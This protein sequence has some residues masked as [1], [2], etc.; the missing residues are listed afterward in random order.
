MFTVKRKYTLEKLS[1]DIHMKREEM[2]QLGLTSGLNSTETIQVS[3]ELDKL[4]LQYQCYKEKQTPKW[5]SIIKVPIF[6]IGY[7]GKSS[8]FWRML[9]DGFMK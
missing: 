9:V 3:Q 4:I 6:Q 7:E 2:I 5:L 1:R 8:N